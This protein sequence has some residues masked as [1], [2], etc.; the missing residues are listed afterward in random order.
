MKPAPK[1]K[2]GGAKRK[3]LHKSQSP[4]ENLS[5]IDCRP[6]G[7][8]PT[9]V[10]IFGLYRESARMKLPGAFRRSVHGQTIWQNLANDPHRLGIVFN[11]VQTFSHMSLWTFVVIVH[12]S[13]MGS[14]AG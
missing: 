4:V 13:N 3:R 7:D 11:R 8:C 2:I 5:W 6:V 9:V 10:W 14:L 12:R 1:L